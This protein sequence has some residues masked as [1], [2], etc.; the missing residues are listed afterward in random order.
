MPRAVIEIHLE[1][2]GWAD[3]LSQLTSQRLHT[4]A[5]QCTV[6]CTGREKC[7]ENAFLAK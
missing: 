1:H 3:Q 7:V 6:Q 4:G 5:V 2:G